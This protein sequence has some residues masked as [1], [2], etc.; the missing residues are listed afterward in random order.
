MIFLPVIEQGECR[1][2]L[3]L[4]FFG[5]VAYHRQA[6]AHGRAIFGEG[7]DDCETAGFDGS[8]G[9][10]RIGAAILRRCEKVEDGPIMPELM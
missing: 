8:Q 3:D 9:R 10:V 4:Q 5:A 7:G 2:E 1:A 6:A